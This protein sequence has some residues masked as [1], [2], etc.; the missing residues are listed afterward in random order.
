MRILHYGWRFQIRFVFNEISDN[1]DQFSKIRCG[2]LK[3]LPN[4]IGGNG[5]SHIIE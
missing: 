2:K 3:I 4:G 1:V 5:L